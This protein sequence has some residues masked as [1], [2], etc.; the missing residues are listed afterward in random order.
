MATEAIVVPVI[1]LANFPAELEKLAAASS[2]LGCFRVINHGIPLPLLAK[3]KETTRSLFDIPDDAK[4]RNVTG[5]FVDGGYVPPNYVPNVPFYESFGIYNAAS[6]ADVHSFCSLL[7][8]SPLQREIIVD[9]V[10][11]LHI[12]TMD[13][14]SKVAESLGLIDKYSF[15]GWSCH[16]RLNY[17]KFKFQEDIGCIG[18]PTHT[19]S[20]FLT[21]VQEDECVGGLEIVD[22]NGNFISVDPLPGTFFVNIGD[23]GKAWSNGRLQNAKHRVI[24]KKAMPRISIVLFLLA[25]E[26]D[27]IEP[28]AAFIDIDHPKLYESYIYNEYRMQRRITGLRAGEILPV[29]TADHQAKMP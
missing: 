24:C 4:L 2:G 15:N 25:P 26:D 27:K 28:Q 6:P 12:L 11:K 10:G 17:Y 14:A 9:Y 3:M 19:D 8:A 20:G 22:A 18:V 13:L 5:N 29:L 1:D 21:V 16:A 23:V 7:D